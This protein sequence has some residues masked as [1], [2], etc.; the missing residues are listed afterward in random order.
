MKKKCL[1]LSSIIIV[2]CIHSTQ[3]VLLNSSFESVYNGITPNGYSTVDDS[4]S[5][6]PNDWAWRKQGNMDGFALRGVWSTD[7]DRCLYMFASNTG[8]HFTGD[9]LEF[10]Q[11]V[12]LTNISNI[13][14]DLLCD[15][16]AVTNSYLA[17]DS[18]KLWISPASLFSDWTIKD[19][20]IDVSSFSGIHELS[21][22]IEMTANISAFADGHT[23]YDNIRFISVPEPFSLFLLA[24]GGLLLRRRKNLIC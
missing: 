10:Y 17:I 5:G 1:Q 18:Q 13:V 3:A 24:M 8:P 22:G 21:L 12:D 11:P 16:R 7:G 2:L 9:Y 14:L 20:N 23:R 19:L 4:Q 15:D 6:L